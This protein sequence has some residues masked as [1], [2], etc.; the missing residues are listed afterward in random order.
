MRSAIRS[1]TFRTKSGPLNLGKAVRI[2]DEKTRR[3]GFTV[4][5]DWDGKANRWVDEMIPIDVLDYFARGVDP[6]K[7][8]SGE[9]QSL[10]ILL[11]FYFLYVTALLAMRVGDDGNTPDNVERVTQ[12]LQDLQG[13]SGS[14]QRI[15]DNT[16]TLVLVAT[17]HFE[18]DAAAYERLIARIRQSWS[19]AQQLQLALAHAAILGSHLRHG[20]Q[21][22][23]ARDLGLMRADNGPDYPCLCF[24]LL[25]LLRTYAR[26]HDQDIH[27]VEREQ[28]VEGIL[29]GLTPDPRAFI[30]KPPAPLA[31]YTVD[32][33]EVSALFL[34]YNQ[35][36]F[37]E[38]ESHRPSD[39]YYS[40]IAFSFNFPHNLVKGMVIDA[41]FKAQPSNVSL[42]GLLTG[43]P[44]GQNG[45][46]ALTRTLM[47]YAR[48]VP[49][50]IGGRPVPVIYYDPALALRTYV[51][52]VGTLRELV[53]NG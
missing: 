23:Y 27:G 13:P 16:G 10:A 15:V 29:N 4:L 33:G 18:P 35:D 19:E 28:V 7:I 38:F 37:A 46:E 31:S 51:K 45:K 25:I 21:D 36:L 26:M 47:G 50:K 48:R 53:S 34:K 11:D 39:Q 3:D 22:L 40:P 20:F 8:G 24:A 30:G 49:D 9:R 6:V 14:G 43:I 17:A 5:I 32:Q 2:L 41:L 42:N 1:H 52:T 44:K 12:L